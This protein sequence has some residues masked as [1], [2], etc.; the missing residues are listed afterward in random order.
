MHELFLAHSNAYCLSVLTHA[1]VAQNFNARLYVAE[2]E[3]VLE[4]GHLIAPLCR[5]ALHHSQ[6]ARV[7][8]D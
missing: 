8:G 4:A 1:G 6:L 7:A 2:E 3:R 5:D